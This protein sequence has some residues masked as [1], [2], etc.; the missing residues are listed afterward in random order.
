MARRT[1]INVILNFL[2]DLYN[3][4]K[5]KRELEKRLKSIR[6]TFVLD[7]SNIRYDKLK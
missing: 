3:D 4:Y 5:Y 1:R 7:N 2:T 6:K